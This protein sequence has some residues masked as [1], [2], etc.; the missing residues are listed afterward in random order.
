MS[1][2]SISVW[3]LFSPGILFI[4]ALFN[5]F[6]DSCI[7]DVGAENLILYFI[8]CAICTALFPFVLLSAI[9]GDELGK[10][11]VSQFVPVLVLWAL[12]YIPF[13]ILVS[14][15]GKSRIP[16]ALTIY[17]WFS[18]NPIEEDV[19]EA[20]RTEGSA[21]D[22]W[23]E[24]GEKVKDAPAGVF[25]TMEARV[26]AERFR[27]HAEE[28]KAEKEWVEASEELMNAAADLEQ[29]KRRKAILEERLRG[30]DERRG[31]RP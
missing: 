19:D 16:S 15:D 23:R 18:R 10:T 6:C 31:R 14:E 7:F 12:S 8:Y 11:I 24:V 13:L 1:R 9:F 25:S 21:T 26:Q 28:V 3:L 2:H 4:I 30:L 5:F 20:L 22:R 27:R 29:A 17:S